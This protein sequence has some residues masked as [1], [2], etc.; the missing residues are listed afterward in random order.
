MAHNRLQSLPQ[1]MF[2]KNK[3]L[4]T[5]K[6]HRNPWNC[7]CRILNI[8][9]LV[10]GKSGPNEEAKCF[11]PPKLRAMPLSS[12]KAADVPCAEPTIV[13]KEFHSILDCTASGGGE[14][15]WLYK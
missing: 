8:G 1:M 7:D 12:V 15:H 2:A 11:N 6:L 5:L 14:V 13:E 9:S 3:R 10:M 4:A